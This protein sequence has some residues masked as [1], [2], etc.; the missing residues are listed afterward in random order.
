[1]K[2]ISWNVNGIRAA[3]RKG[4]ASFVE[5]EQP[6]ILCLQETRAMPDEVET[7]WASG[8]EQHWNPAEKPGYSGTA[9]FSRLPSLGVA[10]GLGSVEHDREGRALTVE[11]TGFFLVNAYVPNAGRELARLP[12]R[13]RWD[14]R[15]VR[16]LKELQTRK[17]VVV[18]GDF[19]VA[20]KEIDLARP[21]QNVG[22]HGFTPQERRGFDAFVRAGLLD[23]FRE[24][25]PGPG[26]Y[27]WW[28]Q[29]GGSRGRNVGWR[30]DYFLVSRVLRP[31]LRGAFI[32]ETVTDS[33][34][35]PVGIEMDLPERSGSM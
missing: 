8:Y 4:F 21:K 32:R 19:N 13:Q 22:N 16:Y 12:Y 31:V 7:L 15:F 24:F 25:E 26:H 33:D 30:I 9:V 3:L 5:S 6:D 20:H 2:I 29:M 28:S 1:M 27:T 23:T 14:R 35:C 18:C 34:H 17:P 10:R 11:Y